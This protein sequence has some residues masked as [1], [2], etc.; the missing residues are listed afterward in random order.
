MTEKQPQVVMTAEEEKKKR[1]QKN[2]RW[3]AVQTQAFT[4]WA[5]ETVQRRGMSVK[6]I[7][8]D[9]STGIVLIN[10]FEL[11]SGKILREKY[12]H[13]PKSRI[14]C[15]ENLHL[16]LQFMEK[17]MKVR[18]PGCSAEDI[19]D[20][21]KNGIKLVL[22]LL[23][24]LFRKFR[25][26]PV[27]LVGGEGTAKM[28]EEDAMLEWVRQTTQ[29]YEGV[30][31]QSYRYS[32]R[33]GKAFL[34]LCHSYSRM[35]DCE[36]FDYVEI[37]KKD[38][39]EILEFAFDYAHKHLGVD[40]LLEVEEVRDGDIDDKALAIY[41]SLY[42]HAFKK[43]KEL[44][45]M[46]NELGAKSGELA[47]QMKSK[48]DLV[49]M[50]LTM[51]KEIEEMT[52]K[53]ELLLQE[54][55]SLDQQIEEAEKANEM[56]KQ[57]IEELDQK[58]TEYKKNIEEY[59]V[60][61]DKLTSE[62]DELEVKT[63]QLGEETNEEDKQRNLLQEELKRLKSELDELDKELDVEKEMRNG[64]DIQAKLDEQT[65][66]TKKLEEEVVE[67]EEQYEENE[68]ISRNLKKKISDI[69][70][71]KKK[72]S[73]ELDAISKEAASYCGALGVLRKQIELH[74]EDLDR[75]SNM[76]EGKS[77][78]GDVD[79]ILMKFSTDNEE[80]SS[81]ERVK[82]LIDMLQHEEEEMEK[83]Y[84]MKVNGGNNKTAKGG[85]KKPVAKK[86]VAKKK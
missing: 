49:Q 30:N 73:E 48:N 56:K 69:E 53:K 44:Q 54:L 83:L 47:L 57:Q 62:N 82:M 78:V 58:M 84:D 2:A 60:K 15:I 38:N 27:D 31:V 70:D 86:P 50:N 23:W 51:T 17:E 41:A 9:F 29:G 77:D 68:E 11:L 24:T 45:E 40:R 32:F 26:N 63:K 75:W 13:S 42:H 79:T 36:Q 25:M 19:I 76:L 61:L 85:K 21:D 39:D 7:S 43:F 64:A 65:K 37:S 28:R 20:A 22:G 71:E 14:Y 18:N 46:K 81:E 59:T 67:L 66:I 35:A 80:K 52:Q 16:A 10:F 33:D 55:V 12:T 3:V 34:A 5:N 8:K 72:Y 4:S 6:D 1:E 74:A